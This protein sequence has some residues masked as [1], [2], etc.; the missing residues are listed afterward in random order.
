MVA[1]E[2]CV[3]GELETEQS[4]NILTPSSSGY[5][6][7]SFSFCWAAQPE[8]WEPSS[9]LGASSHS[10]E[11]QQLTPNYNYNSLEIPVAPGYMIVW[12]SLLQWASH[13]HPTQPVHSQGYPQISS[14][15]CTC[16]LHRCISHLTAW[17]GR[18]SICYSS[19]KVIAQ[20]VRL[21]E[22][23]SNRLECSSR[24]IKILLKYFQD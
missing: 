3:K 14:T 9:Q 1:K 17:P 4:C 2:L 22:N 15:G 18:R 10:F 12:R 5:S 23:E 16:Y 19:P 21:F 11:L 7:A 8:A 6:S 24:Y 13:L 20:Q